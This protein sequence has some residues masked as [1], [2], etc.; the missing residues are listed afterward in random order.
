MA[1]L[2]GL[3]KLSRLSSSLPRLIRPSRSLLAKWQQE[4]T[5]FDYSPEPFHPISGKEPVWMSSEQAVGFITSGRDVGL[6]V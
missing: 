1:V 2:G 3:G 6:A 4:R 5:Y